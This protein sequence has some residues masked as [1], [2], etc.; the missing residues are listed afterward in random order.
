MRSFLRLTAL[1]LCAAAFVWAQGTAQIHGTI[2]DATGAAV[3]GA[4]VKATQT[5]TGLTRTVTTEADGGTVVF[6]TT[7]QGE[8]VQGDLQW[9]C[10][11]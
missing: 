9:G 11:R 1:L 5:D 2:Q 8:Q 3:P 4:E 7:L 6:D 10:S